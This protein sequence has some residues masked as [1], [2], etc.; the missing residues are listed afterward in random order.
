[1]GESVGVNPPA[2]PGAS[3]L[4]DP[5]NQNLSKKEKQEAFCALPLVGAEQNAS[6]G[7]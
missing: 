7:D 5:E 6:E 3:P 1:M 2:P 4:R